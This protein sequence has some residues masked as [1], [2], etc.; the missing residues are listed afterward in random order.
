MAAKRAVSEERTC[1]GGGT[2]A[3]DESE[4]RCGSKE[5]EPKRDDIHESEIERDG[6]GDDEWEQ[7]GPKNKSTLSDKSTNHIVHKPF[8]RKWSLISCVHFAPCIIMQ[9]TMTVTQPL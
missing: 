7:V 1:G 3:T 2:K 9:Y 5:A 6:N 4:K 8:V